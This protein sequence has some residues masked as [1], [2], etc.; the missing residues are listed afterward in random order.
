VNVPA[1]T[2]HARKL[3]MALKITSSVSGVPFVDTASYAVYLVKDV[4]VVETGAGT[5]STSVMGHATNAST[6]TEE[7]LDY[8][9]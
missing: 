2:F 6:G 8:T 7:L 5:V 1:G 4:G 9:P 3:Q